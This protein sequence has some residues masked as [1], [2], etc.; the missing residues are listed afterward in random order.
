MIQV[1]G[2]SFNLCARLARTA[3]GILSRLPRVKQLTIYHVK[4]LTE[5]FFKGDLEG[6]GVPSH[7]GCHSRGV[8]RRKTASNKATKFVQVQSQN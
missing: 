3:H 1:F 2:L 7:G 6:D 5:S 4:I 8:S